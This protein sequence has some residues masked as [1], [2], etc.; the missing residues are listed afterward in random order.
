MLPASEVDPSPRSKP[1]FGNLH[2]NRRF[3]RVTPHGRTKVDGQCMLFALVH[4]AP[5]LPPSNA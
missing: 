3:N 4:A 5:T 2:A 1:V